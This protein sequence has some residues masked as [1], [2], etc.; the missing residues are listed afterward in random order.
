VLER[1]TLDC[2]ARHFGDCWDLHAIE[3]NLRKG[4]T[5]HPY[6]PLRAITTG[7]FDPDS[8]L[9]LLLTGQPLHEVASDNI[10]DPRL[11]GLLP[12][13]L[14]ETID[15]QVFTTTLPGRA[16]RLLSVGLP[17]GV[18]QAGYDFHGQQSRCGLDG[19][20]RNPAGVAG[21]RSRPGAESGSSRARAKRA[22]R[23]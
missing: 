16:A 6:M 7:H 21:G 10:A 1:H 11:R 19:V 4:G 12:A 17:V 8:Y 13:D 15:R 20:R 23:P 22:G 2:I 5:T 9:F 18:R 14:V 3:A